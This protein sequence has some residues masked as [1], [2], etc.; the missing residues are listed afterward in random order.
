MNNPADKDIP[1]GDP[2][3][4]LKPIAEGVLTPVEAN[5]SRVLRRL[6]EDDLSIHPGAEIDNVVLIEQIGAGGMGEV[7]LGH[8]RDI[9]T[10]IAVKVMPA[11][12]TNDRI[13]GLRFLREAHAAGRLDHP[14]IVRIY[15]H[16]VSG[17][18]RYILMEYVDGLDLSQRA[19]RQGLLTPEQGLRMVRQVAMALEHAASRGV[20]HRDIKPS[21]LMIT[22]SGQIKVA[23]FGL[24]TLSSREEGDPNDVYE[25]LTHAQAFVGTPRYAAPEQV[26]GDRTDVRADIYSLGVTLLELLC[27][28]AVFDPKTQSIFGQVS[29][30]QPRFD[31]PEFLALPATLRNLIH[32]LC[33]TQA[34]DRPWPTAL[35]QAVDDMLEGGSGER[36][37]SRWT[38]KP[39]RSFGLG[40]REVLIGRDAELI[41]LAA[42][43]ESPGVVTICGPA[44][45]G[46]TSLARLAGHHCSTNRQ[47]GVWFCDLRECTIEGDL[48]KAVARGLDIQQLG[49]DPLDTI[50]RTITSRPD[51]I[52]IFDNCEQI[53]GPVRQLL[54]QMRERQP[55][56]SFL[57]TSREPL[58]AL[59]ERVFQLSPLSVPAS[60][61]I[62]TAD[63]VSPDI[64]ASPAVQLFVSLAAKAR[65]GFALTQAN[66]DTIAKLVRRLDGLPL[67]LSLAAARASVLT[68]ESMLDRLNRR[69]DLLSDATSG[70]RDS[71]HASLKAAL[72]WSWDLLQP[73]E[74]SAMAQLSVCVGGFTLETAEEVVN[75]KHWPDAPWVMDIV[76]TLVSKQ[77]LTAT[78]DRSG[79]LR[80]NMLESVREFSSARL[81]KENWPLADRKSVEARHW[82]H[83]AETG[84]PK[85]A[86]DLMSGHRRDRMIRDQE[87]YLA[88]FRRAL[89]AGEL[90]IASRSGIVAAALLESANQHHDAREVL[91]QVFELPVANRDAE[92]LR[93]VIHTQVTQHYHSEHETVRFARETVEMAKQQSDK[94]L[95][96]AAYVALSEVGSNSNW[97]IEHD[98]SAL[99]Y[100]I[101]KDIPG[102][103]EHQISLLRVMAKCG[104]G[105]NKQA[106]AEEYLKKAYSLLK[107]G[108]WE[109]HSNLL[110][111]AEMFLR[112]FKGYLRQAH[113]LCR[114]NDE[115]MAEISPGRAAV[116]SLSAILYRFLGELDE[117][118][119]HFDMRELYT[120]VR[121]DLVND[122]IIRCHRIFIEFQRLGPS[123]AGEQLLL[124]EAPTIPDHMRYF[125]AGTPLTGLAAWSATVRGDAEAGLRYGKKAIA[126]A[127]AHNLTGM[128]ARLGCSCA[129]AGNGDFEQAL[130]MA[131]LAVRAAISDWHERTCS[132]S[133]LNW[134]RLR[135]LPHLSDAEA[136]KQLAE[137]DKFIAERGA[138]LEREQVGPLSLMRQMFQQVLNLRQS[139]G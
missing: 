69:F 128:L 91:R 89:N 20:A 73:W 100:D 19:R 49:K 103:E 117:A 131:D 72:E 11:R 93:R 96:V 25:T 3:S 13:Q 111:E 45:V 26:M 81:D 8:D 54:G 70:S 132:E 10:Q 1:S 64:A 9:G 75:V 112:M 42:Q 80:F 74:R 14:N 98:N 68:V 124:R 33:S 126:D 84:N 63:G 21:N 32:A 24:A 108:M 7:W 65:P 76:Q 115:E 109:L 134:I 79:N 52:I 113:S 15:R 129:L 28:R 48:Y 67:A 139:I 34:S 23:D 78:S 83:F 123:E 59:S 133:N 31:T 2:W 92:L 4:G 41:Q 58:S 39:V 135:Q 138:W 95:L 88:A 116:S 119:K 22:N 38:A 47:H 6:S 86:V 36:A 51:S 94:M 120:K 35:V 27:G 18:R 29:E 17:G 106:E 82:N 130:P 40:A 12:F 121:G 101:L 30:F 16:G 71:R 122:V 44:G 55:D 105:I 57:L 50:L 53:L 104:A 43:L 66:A 77:L 37:M 102:T 97:D 127:D 110:R 90:E 114:R 85:H 118:I 46:K 56:N 87:N 60:N 137:V 5:F 61:L 125:V 99:A 107:P 62:P 136:E